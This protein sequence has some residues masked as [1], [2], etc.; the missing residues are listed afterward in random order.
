MVA[1]IAQL[2]VEIALSSLLNELHALVDCVKHVQPVALF[3]QY[4]EVLAMPANVEKLRRNG[5]LAGPGP[6]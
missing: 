2:E 3:Q 4:R 6:R 1:N 5:R